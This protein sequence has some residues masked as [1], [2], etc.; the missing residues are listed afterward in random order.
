[1]NQAE[2]DQL[3]SMFTSHLDQIQGLQP[4]NFQGAEALYQRTKMFAEKYY[5]ARGYG[6]ELVGIKFRPTSV[7][8]E[9][10]SIIWE[11]GITKLLSIAQAMLDD[12]AL[13]PIT[14]PRSAPAP[15]A[16]VVEDTTK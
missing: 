3:V 7:F 10:P 2:K 12:T 4:Y 16:K 5:P 9:S 15:T 8:F 1:M 14:V 11:I 6:V 13:T